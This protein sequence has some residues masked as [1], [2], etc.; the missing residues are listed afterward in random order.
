M[1]RAPELLYRGELVEGTSDARRG[2]DHHR[3]G[4]QGGEPPQKLSAC[5]AAPQVQ[6]QSQQA[7]HPDRRRGQRRTGRGQ[8]AGQEQP[9]RQI[10][11]GGWP[12]GAVSAACGG[13]RPVPTANAITPAIEWPSSVNPRQ[14][15]V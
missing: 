1:A 12:L 2:E 5:S 14:R 4:R 7:A 6:G 3:R 9:P 11:S 13:A 15:I 8:N 10:C